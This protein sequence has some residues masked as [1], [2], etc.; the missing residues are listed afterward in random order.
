MRASLW[1]GLMAVLA[2]GVAGCDVTDLDLDGNTPPVADAGEAQTLYVGETVE[3]DGWGSSD[4][5]G[6]DLTYAWSFA[7]KPDTSAA[8]IQGASSA[9]ATFVPDVPGTYEI[10]L[11][12]SDGEDSDTDHVTVTAAWDLRLSGTIDSDTTLVDRGEPYTITNELYINA[13]V[14]IEP[15]VTIE[16][17]GGHGIEVETGG[18]L[19]AIGTATDSIWFV[20]SN[21]SVG[22]WAG[23]TFS[24]VSPDNV[25]SYVVVAHTG[26]Y[27]NPALEVT[28]SGRLG[29]THSTVRDGDGFGLYLS[30]TRGLLTAFGENRFADMGLGSVMASLDAL[31][32]LDTLTTY[33]GP[34]TLYASTTTAG[35]TWKAID[36]EYHVSSDVA[37]EH[38]VVVEPG[39]VFRFAG[40]YGLLVDGSGSLAAVGTE[41]DTIKFLG[42]EETAGHWDGIEFSTVAA[43]NELTYVEVAHTG[44]YD[45]SAVQVE[46]DGRVKITNS[47]FHD[48]SSYGLHL[49]DASGV[50]PVFTANTFAN[51]GMGAVL[52]S[53]ENVGALDGASTYGDPVEV[54]SS[55]T[56]TD[57]TWKAIDSY[58][59]LEGHVE[60]ES[61]VT[62]EPGAEFE[63]A[64]SRE[65][66]VGINGS[67]SAVG[68]ETAPIR[69]VGENDAAEHWQGISISSRNAA[70][71]L[72]WVEV[73]NGGL[74]QE[75]AVL[76]EASGTLKIR[77]S[78]LR[79]SEGF[80]LIAVSGSELTEFARNT[81]TGNTVA[82]LR[83]HPEH[84]SVVD[85]TSTFT[86]NTGDYVEVTQ[87][88]ISAATS[89]NPLA[90]PYRSHG[91]AIAAP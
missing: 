89:W 55:H 34:V 12:V 60:I 4:D 42:Y 65:I 63:V 57:A 21:A 3:L 36:T 6:D 64:E 33:G 51:F 17:D 77:D 52:L 54:F 29:L 22:H 87:G 1:V 44:A 79:T 91:V 85:A 31:P 84:L 7:A 27:E 71:E 39:A 88:D 47:Y 11:T 32:M 80:G 48:G 43:A 53:A 78:T 2:L 90:V 83:I 81:V 70:N 35:G 69:F 13:A 74:Y 19:T 66:V 37:V 50:L 20:G 49:S 40:G 68:T 56:A 75:A 45:H 8:T 41:T 5:D 24:T 76:L 25:L 23:I 67:L 38:A 14:V 82:A 72:A 62:V 15:G 9:G 46:T 16:V 86:G 30:D 73:A 59:Y 58:Y 61:A 26:L 28:N 10:A 18:S